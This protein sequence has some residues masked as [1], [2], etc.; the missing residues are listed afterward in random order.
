MRAWGF[1]SEHAEANTL[2]N[3]Q[4]SKQ[5]SPWSASSAK[6]HDHSVIWGMD[7]LRLDATSESVTFTRPGLS[8]DMG[9]IGK[10]HA[11]DLAIAALESAGITNAIIHAGT[12]SIRTIG[13]DFEFSPH[14]QHP[15]WLI[16]NSARSKPWRLGVQGATDDSNANHTIIID[17]L[18]ACGD[19]IQDQKQV[20]GAAIGVSAQ[21]G[22][23]L[24]LHQSGANPSAIGH[25]MDP[26]TGHPAASQ[27]LT[28]AVMIPAQISN[29]T[30]TQSFWQTHPGAIADALSTAALVLGFAPCR[31]ASSLGANQISGQIPSRP[32]VA[33]LPSS[34]SGK[35]DLNPTYPC[36]RVYLQCF[37]D[38]IATWNTSQQPFP[39]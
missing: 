10:G 7:K 14:P 1:R 16:G 27:V 4:A 23:T 30:K 35:I 32:Y 33:T 25:I 24:T 22:R 3:T 20:S 28:A 9:A 36:W 13:H 12:S 17:P 19:T 2:D 26:R 21:R 38:G 6:D 31:P 34:D 29:S 11:L 8:L 37:D 39:T 18:E 15:H 5:A